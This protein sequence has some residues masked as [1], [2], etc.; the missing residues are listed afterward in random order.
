IQEGCFHVKLCPTY[1][2]DRPEVSFS[3]PMFHPKIDS[4][5]GS[6]CLSRLDDWQSCY[7]LLDLIK[8]ISYLID[9]PG[10]DLL[11]NSFGCGNLAAAHENSEKDL[12][13]QHLYASH[14]G[15]LITFS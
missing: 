2:K 6:V 5:Y 8:A 7:S 12:V 1:P 10:F 4:S 13:V 14:R 9:H 11:N 15:P 3:S